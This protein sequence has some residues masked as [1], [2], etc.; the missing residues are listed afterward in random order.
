VPTEGTTFNV[1]KQAS[2][3]ALKNASYAESNP[4]V[5]SSANHE[6][7]NPI[8]PLPAEQDIPPSSAQSVSA[9]S[10]HNPEQPQQQVEHSGSENSKEEF[11]ASVSESDGIISVGGTGGKERSGERSSSPTDLYLYGPQSDFSDGPE[12]VLGKR[13]GPP[14]DPSGDGE[15]REG[16]DNEQEQSDAT[17]KPKVDIPMT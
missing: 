12:S 6:G 2:T 13:K 11:K 8:V 5:L 4:R 10:A 15:E 14:Q 9:D 7:T 17:K 3:P 1:E 16:D